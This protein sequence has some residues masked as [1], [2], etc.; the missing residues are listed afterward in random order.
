MDAACNDID[1]SRQQDGTFDDEEV[2]SMSSLK[3]IEERVDILTDRFDESIK[4][5]SE[6]GKQLAVAEKSI[7]HLEDALKTVRSEMVTLGLTMSTNVAS[8]E[9]ALSRKVAILD[10]KILGDDQREGELPKVAKK[11][12]KLETERTKVLA[13]LAFVTFQISFV[14]F[15]IKLY[16]ALR[17]LR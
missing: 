6:A 11:V 15:L 9:A 16:E 13:I 5:V 7:E 12:T 14:L 10:A 2:R 1:N 8:V 17:P 4:F 3:S